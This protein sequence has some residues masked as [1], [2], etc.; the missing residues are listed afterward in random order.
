MMCPGIEYHK[1]IYIPRI[2]KTLTISG[3]K[4]TLQSYM[5]DERKE[6]MDLYDEVH[7]IYS[8]RKYMRTVKKKRS[9]LFFNKENDLAKE[10]GDFKAPG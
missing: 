5:S 10:N 3:L 4:K 6:S 9:T 8:S 7:P 1:V 2:R